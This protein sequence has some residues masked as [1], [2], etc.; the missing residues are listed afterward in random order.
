MREKQFLHSRKGEMP[1]AKQ[2]RWAIRLTEE[3]LA[4]NRD[5]GDTFEG[6]LYGGYVRAL[7]TLIRVAE[8][9]L[10]PRRRCRVR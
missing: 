4:R 2:I 6:V 10:R 5:H 3:M 8:A 1:K 9:S 7:K